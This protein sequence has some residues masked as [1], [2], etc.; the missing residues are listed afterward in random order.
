MGRPSLDHD[1]NPI[2]IFGYPLV[3]DDEYQTGSTEGMEF[4][5]P[6]TRH[7][8][9]LITDEGLPWKLLLTRAEPE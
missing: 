1:G 4:G 7:D 9:K 2:T 5:F 6:V 3:E 8:A